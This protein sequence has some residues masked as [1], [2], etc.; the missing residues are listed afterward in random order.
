MAR[1]N[2]EFEIEYDFFL[3][4]INCHQKDYRLCWSI[5]QALGINLERTEDYVL[6]S[7]TG[8]LVGFPHFKYDDEAN[9][10]EFHLFKNKSGEGVLIPEQ[11]VADYLLK[12]EH[13][14]V[15]P[16]DEL[17]KKIRELDIVLTAYQLNLESLTSKENLIF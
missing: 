15:T 9:K 17:I 11:R 12:V 10:N 6:K 4:G 13:D 7:K 3:I 8:N 1:Y 5:N 16:I 2:L 14:E